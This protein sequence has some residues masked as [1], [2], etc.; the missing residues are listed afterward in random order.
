L[1]NREAGSIT[2]SPRSMSDIEII[3]T[4]RKKPC[5]K[6]TGR[7]RKGPVRSRMGRDDLGRRRARPAGKLQFLDA[8]QIKVGGLWRYND[9]NL[10]YPEPASTPVQSDISQL[11]TY[12][13]GIPDPQ[14]GT[15][16]RPLGDFK[17]VFDAT[18]GT[19][20]IV[21]DGEMIELSA[22]NADFTADGIGVDQSLL[23]DAGEVSLGFLAGTDPGRTHWLDF[24]EGILQGDDAEF[25]SA[26]VKITAEAN[27]AAAHP[28][29]TLGGNHPPPPPPPPGRARLRVPAAGV[30]EDPAAARV[31]AIRDRH[32]RWV[33]RGGGD[34]R[35]R[36]PVPLAR[37]FQFG[38]ADEVPQHDLVRR[39]GDRGFSR[40]AHV[41]GDA[42]S[43]AAARFDSAGDT[44]E[45]RRGY[46]PGV[47]V[48][49]AVILQNGQRYYRW[50]HF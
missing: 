18:N 34:P 43:A 47:W 24:G 5:R 14:I 4:R 33:D 41:F 16:F 6:G 2:L 7:G 35:S 29:L 25:A 12:L 22:G 11:I 1:L 28:P 48:P 9:F 10:P 3:I 21:V 26:G 17:S 31:V 32:D 13:E 20:A 15:L 23:D 44:G 36:V 46:D 50:Q 38:D 27:S 30:R 37:H 39:G 40:N 49:T 8:A 42:A 19:Y 45:V